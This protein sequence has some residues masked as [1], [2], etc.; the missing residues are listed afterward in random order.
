M[1][2]QERLGNSTIAITL[3][4][5]SHVALGIQEVAAKRFDE[6]LVTSRGGLTD[7]RRVTV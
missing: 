4:T 1:D 5:Y 3:D 7:D 6:I 2:V